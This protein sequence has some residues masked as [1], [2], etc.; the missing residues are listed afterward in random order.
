MVDCA[1]IWA[2]ASSSR[3]QNK[4]LMGVVIRNVLKMYF[5]EF[6]KYTTLITGQISRSEEVCHMICQG[7]YLRAGYHTIA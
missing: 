4:E 7:K 2:I 1:K 5:F 3:I 6:E